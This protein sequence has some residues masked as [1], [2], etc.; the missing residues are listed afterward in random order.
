MPDFIQRWLREWLAPPT[1]DTKAFAARFRVKHAQ[2]FENYDQPDKFFTSAQRSLLV[3]NIL[4][5]TPFRPR[6]FHR[7][8]S[9]DVASLREGVSDEDTIGIE[10][11][12]H[13]GAYLDAFPL[14]EDSACDPGNVVFFAFFAVCV[15]LMTKN[16]YTDSCT[17][18]PPAESRSPREQLAYEWANYRRW[19]KRQPM[20]AIRAYFGEYIAFYF[21][22][23]GFYTRQ[24]ILPAV[25]GVLV[26]VYGLASFS[27]R[28][29]SK[30]L[31]AADN[32][33]MCALC[34]GCDQVNGQCR[35]LGEERGEREREEE[36]E[37]EEDKKNAREQP[38][39]VVVG[40][41]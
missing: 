9:T 40:Y 23:L 20:D 37:E 32:V 21:V 36:E 17:K 16:V 4:C 38:I 12:L 29:D 3:W 18:P 31:C 34:D 14:H 27:G 13:H 33:T 22:W 1:D 19:T 5:N 2:K 28:T 41:N 24:L 39:I 7:A 26:M 25:I 30:E 8:E 15:I 35:D 11:L 6:R 10:R